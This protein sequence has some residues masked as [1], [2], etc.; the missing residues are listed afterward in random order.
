MR[1]I[2]IPRKSSSIR[3]TTYR[4]GEKIV[5]LA[6]DLRVADLQVNELIDD[7]IAWMIEDARDIGY[8]QAME[9]VRNLIGAK[10][11]K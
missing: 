5:I 2:N 4:D 10:G 9:D 11:V 3:I 8:A 7:R 1:L 6:N